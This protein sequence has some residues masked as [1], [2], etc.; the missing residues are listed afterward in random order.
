MAAVALAGRPLPA[1]LPS[2][3]ALAQALELEIIAPLRTIRR[4]LVSGPAAVAA[5]DRRALREAIARDELEAERLLL[6]VLE[7][8]VSQPAPPAPA[9][10]AL[11]EVA[12]AWGGRAPALLLA[13]LGAAC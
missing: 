6:A 13:M 1:E 2:A 5:D 7:R 11:A 12:A 10:M 3:V 9:A 8:L 4:R